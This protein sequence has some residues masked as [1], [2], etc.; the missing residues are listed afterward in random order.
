MHRTQGLKHSRV[1]QTSKALD[2]E[3]KSCL[4][5][6]RSRLDHSFFQSSTTTADTADTAEE[7]NNMSV[8]SVKERAKHLNR[9]ESEAELI[10]QTSASSLGAPYARKNLKDVKKVKT[11]WISPTGNWYEKYDGLGLIKTCIMM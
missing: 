8:V 2:N 10:Q 6:M 5:L 4:K 11:A 9:M 7:D 3:K 1:I